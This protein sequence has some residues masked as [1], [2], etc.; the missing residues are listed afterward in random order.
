MLKTATESLICSSCDVFSGE[1]FCRK[2]FEHSRLGVCGCCIFVNKHAR[3]KSEQCR[4]GLSEPYECCIKSGFC[5]IASAEDVIFLSKDRI[6]QH[7][8]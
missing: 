3:V 8:M 5:K 6:L 7:E 1:S 2:I 4:P